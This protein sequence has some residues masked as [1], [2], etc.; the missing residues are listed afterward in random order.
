MV[1]GEVSSVCEFGFWWFLK[2]WLLVFIVSWLGVMRLLFMV[3][4]I[5]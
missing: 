3:M 5:E 1:I 2:L 4:Y